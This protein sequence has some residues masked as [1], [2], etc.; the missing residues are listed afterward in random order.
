[1]A[2]GLFF[3]TSSSICSVALGDN[4]TVLASEEVVKENSH[5]S[6]LVPLVN[7]VLEKAKLSLKDVDYFGVSKGPGSYTGLR[8]GV[9][10]AK[11]FA[12][13][14]DK[15]LI[16][17]NTLKIMANEAKHKKVG[18]PNDLLYP[19]LDARRKEVYS[20]VYDFNLNE[21]RETKAEILDESF[22]TNSDYQ[23]NYFGQ[24]AD[25]AKEFFSELKNMKFTAAIAP[26][27]FYMVGIGYQQFKAK[28]FEDVAYFEPFYLKEFLSKVSQK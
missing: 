28:H 15:P 26:K 17:V 18:N 23:I 13:A 2:I 6:L 20:A 7:K 3:E 22:Y 24:G 10:T 16:S 11:G 27:S 9:S 4:E 8:I 5:S 25:K 19:M 1:M 12:Y 21:V 14:C